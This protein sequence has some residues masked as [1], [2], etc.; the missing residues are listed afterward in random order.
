MYQNCTRL[1]RKGEDVKMVVVKLSRAGSLRVDAVRRYRL[2]VYG[3]NACGDKWYDRKEI[4]MWV[5]GPKWY[6]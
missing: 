1:Y 3:L 2:S 5:F 4:A 6:A